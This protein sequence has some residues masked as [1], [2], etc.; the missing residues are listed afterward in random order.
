MKDN[1]H[2][3]MGSSKLL[4]SA[5]QFCPHFATQYE[6]ILNLAVHYRASTDILR[7][8]IDRLVKKNMKFQ[9]YKE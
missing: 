5:F 8:L 1:C 4:N 6:N 2:D 3:W 7:H 9:S